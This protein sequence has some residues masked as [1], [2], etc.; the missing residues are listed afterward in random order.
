M[1]KK[2]KNNFKTFKFCL[3]L[4]IFLIKLTNKAFTSRK[5]INCN[6]N[7]SNKTVKPFHKPDIPEAVLGLFPRFRNKPLFLNTIELKKQS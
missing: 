1:G 6:W 5:R 4:Y 3:F 2:L 7:M